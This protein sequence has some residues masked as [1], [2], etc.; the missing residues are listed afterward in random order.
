M[1]GFSQ[2]KKP[3]GVNMVQAKTNQ[4]GVF[5]P[6]STQEEHFIAVI[7]DVYR[8]KGLGG[9]EQYN[10]IVTSKSVTF[11][12]I[13]ASPN[14][15]PATRS[16]GSKSTGEI[17]AENKKNFS[18][19]R[20]QIKSFRFTPGHSYTDCCR[21]LQEIDGELEIAAPK[22]RYSFYVPFRRNNIAI[23]VLSKAEL[24]STDTGKTGPDAEHSPEGGSR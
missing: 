15:V 2:G 5:S 14:G 6:S 16:Y 20:E 1:S 3:G 19:E 12:L 7:P 13:K 23:D 4:I 22:A 17:L 24:F 11:A 18:I 8:G 10:V 21:K 9:K